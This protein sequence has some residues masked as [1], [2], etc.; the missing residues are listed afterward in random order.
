M[1]LPPNRRQI[2]AE[3]VAEVLKGHRPDL[4]YEFDA[5]T[6]VITKDGRDHYRIAAG[7]ADQQFGAMTYWH[8]YVYAERNKVLNGRPDWWPVADLSWR[9]RANHEIVRDASDIAHK[10]LPNLAAHFPR[11]AEEPAERPSTNPRRRKADGADR[12]Q[13]HK[14]N[15][16]GT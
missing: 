2:M 8:G 6:L 3:D 9:C 10:L 13:V 15:T 5:S 11:A 1:N 16:M 14:I 4:R 7:F 12:Q